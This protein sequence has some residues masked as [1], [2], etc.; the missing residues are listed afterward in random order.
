MEEYGASVPCSHFEGDYFVDGSG[1]LDDWAYWFD[2]AAV[3]GDKLVVGGTC[4][5]RLEE[6]VAVLLAGRLVLVVHMDFLLI[7]ISFR[8]LRKFFFIESH[9]PP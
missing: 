9:I 4:G 1:D 6:V 3:V 8:L 5:N 7:Y 2:I